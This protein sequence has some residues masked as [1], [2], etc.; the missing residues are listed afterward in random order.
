[1]A[2]AV[3]HSEPKASPP[4]AVALGLAVGFPRDAI[5]VDDE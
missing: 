2:V 1:L 5:D 4:L 3:D